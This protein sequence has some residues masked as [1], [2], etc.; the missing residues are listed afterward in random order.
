MSG[1]AYHDDHILIE[2]D[3]GAVEVYVDYYDTEEGGTQSALIRGRI[4]P[5]ERGAL[6]EYRVIA[7][8]FD[9]E[10]TVQDVHLL[11]EEGR[12]GPQGRGRARYGASRFVLQP[13]G[14]GAPTTKEKRRCWILLRGPLRPLPPGLATSRPMTPFGPSGASCCRSLRC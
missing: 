10:G 11:G 14:A 12:I 5:L 13:P 3:P 4:V 9:D 1:H 8:F 2:N 7:V 6:L